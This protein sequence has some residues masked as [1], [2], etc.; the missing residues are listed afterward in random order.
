MIFVKNKHIDKPENND[1]YIGRGSPLGNPFTHM[2]VS[3]TLAKYKCEDRDDCIQKY[4]DYL[5]EKILTK[6]RT[7]CQELNRIYL[8][9]KKQDVNL[10]CF[11]KPRSC[12]GDIIKK[13]L[14]EKL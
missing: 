7:I 3:K 9:A 8:L 6:D 11:C 2:D 12:H 4:E 5:R 10:V 14:E 1:I 13:I